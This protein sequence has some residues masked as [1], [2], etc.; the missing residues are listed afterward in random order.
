MPWR[1]ATGSCSFKNIS[2]FARQWLAIFKT[3]GDHA[4]CPLQVR[5]Q[6]LQAAVGLF[7]ALGGDF[8]PATLAAGAA[9]P[10]PAPSSVVE[11]SHP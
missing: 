9:S 7:R 5:L 2:D 11:T 10:S 3:V 6:H 4:Q 1:Q 8:A